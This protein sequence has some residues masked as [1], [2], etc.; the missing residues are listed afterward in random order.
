M[1]RSEFVLRGENISG[2][3][4]DGSMFFCACALTFGSRNRFHSRGRLSD[5]R[6]TCSAYRRADDC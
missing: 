1:G 2:P 4:G 3:V 6:I 5:K